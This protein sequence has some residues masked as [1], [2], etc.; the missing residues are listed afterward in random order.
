MAKL[1]APSEYMIRKHDNDRNRCR[2]CDFF[3]PNYPRGVVH[4]AETHH[5]F[6]SVVVYKNA[7][8]YGR[9]DVDPAEN[10]RAAGLTQDDQGVWR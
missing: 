3:R 10:Y 8:R 1:P 6:A 2:G 7:T 5:T 4:S 9:P